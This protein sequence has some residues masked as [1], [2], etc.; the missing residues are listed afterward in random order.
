MKNLTFT[1]VLWVIIGLVMLVAIVQS[2][3]ETSTS[4]SSQSYDLYKSATD[5]IDS[6]QAHLL[7]KQEAQRV[8]DVT[9][10]WCSPCNTARRLCKHGR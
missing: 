5:K 9:V 7:T 2:S 3:F 1:E 4:S 10:G 6:G 8:H